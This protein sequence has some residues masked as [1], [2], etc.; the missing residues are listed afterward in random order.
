MIEKP[1]KLLWRFPLDSLFLKKC[2]IHMQVLL[3][4][5]Q[6]GYDAKLLILS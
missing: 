2:I 4:I 5:L 1:E 3:Y 6:E